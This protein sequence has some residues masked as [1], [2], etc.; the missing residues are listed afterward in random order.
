M[1]IGLNRKK[2]EE[3]A[4]VDDLRTRRIGRG[5]RVSSRSYPT[6]V[7]GCEMHHSTLLKRIHLRL[8][9]IAIGFE[10][11]LTLIYV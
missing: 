10:L 3:N 4:G 11:M 5:Q 6:K 8:K 1:P 7:A 9:V 2:R